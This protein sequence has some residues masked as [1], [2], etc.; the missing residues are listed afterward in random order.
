MFDRV[1]LRECI[2]PHQPLRGGWGYGGEP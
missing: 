1:A 2:S